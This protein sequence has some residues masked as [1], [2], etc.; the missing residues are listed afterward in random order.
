MDLLKRENWWV[1]LILAIFGGG[2]VYNIILGVFLKS[3]DENAWYTKWWIWIIGVFAFFLPFLIMLLIF[4]IQLQ[5]TNAKKL[6]VEGQEIYG[7]PYFWI[8]GVIIPII[9]WIAIGIMNLYLVIAILIKLNAGE[10]EKFIEVQ[11]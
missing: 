3:Y 8:L 7:T 11:K 4:S 6:N 1:W 9:G 5:V 10:G 2:L